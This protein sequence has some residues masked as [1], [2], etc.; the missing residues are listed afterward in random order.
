M[1]DAP[2]VCRYGDDV[3]GLGAAATLMGGNHRCS[4][5]I[6][7]DD[8]AVTSKAATRAAR[9]SSA[10]C[11]TAASAADSMD[12]RHPIARCALA[13]GVQITLD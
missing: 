6:R 12:V 7:S 1:G 3:R 9:W 5:F 8:D 2:L 13:N 10:T 4:W 11:G